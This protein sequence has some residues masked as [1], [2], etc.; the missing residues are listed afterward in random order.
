MQRAAEAFKRQGAR[1]VIALATHGVCSPD[2]P[3]KLGSEALDRVFLSNTIPLSL[4]DTL[5]ESKV[6]VVDVAPL[7]GEAIGSLHLGKSVTDLES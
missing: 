2:T 1:K 4:P 3:D 6:K 5:L 7:V